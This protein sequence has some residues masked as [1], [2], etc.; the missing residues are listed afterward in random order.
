[1]FQLMVC[2]SEVNIKIAICMVK[3][4]DVRP[5]SWSWPRGQKLR[6]WPWSCN[7]KVLALALASD[8][9]VLTLALVLAIGLVIVESQYNE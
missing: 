6:P 7:M 2:T 8:P 3:S 9:K 4:R 5:R 1:M